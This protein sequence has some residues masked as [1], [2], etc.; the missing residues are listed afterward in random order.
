MEKKTIKKRKKE[1]YFPLKT[2]L[3]FSKNADIPSFWSSVEKLEEKHAISKAQAEARSFSTPVFTNDLINP[4]CTDD[5]PA[6]C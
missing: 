3:R 4:V 1:N 6:I 2:G 5:F